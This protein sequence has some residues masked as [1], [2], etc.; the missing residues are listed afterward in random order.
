MSSGPAVAEPIP[1]RNTQG[2]MHGFLLLK[3]GDG[4]V[5]GTGDM[6]QVVHG[7]DVHSRLVFRFRDG[8]LDDD[9]AVFQQGRTLQLL[10]DHHVQKGPSFPKPLDFTIDV[11]KSAATW[12]EFKDGKVEVKTEH[13]DVPDN[14][15]NGMVAIVLQNVAPSMG[16]AKVSYVVGSP[17]P[18]VV[19][20]S[21]KPEG[22]ESYLL[23]GSIRKAKKYRI[24]IDLGG[25]VGVVAPIIG[26]QPADI[27]IWVADGEVPTVVKIEGALYDGGPIWTIVQTAPA[28][29]SVPR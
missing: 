17:K 18:R 11:A 12:K 9:T 21:M 26:K 4:K 15:A 7:R 19:R 27:S 25:L 2:A 16:E 23:G 20:L 24:H 29:P 5:I 28:W 13:V 14:A 6:I 3:S 22:L 1:A 8:S 10:S